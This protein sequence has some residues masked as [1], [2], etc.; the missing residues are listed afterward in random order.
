M[1]V[2]RSN[3]YAI[4]PEPGPSLWL[5][6]MAEDKDVNV[7]QLFDFIERYCADVSA[8]GQQIRRARLFAVFGLD[9]PV[10]NLMVEFVEVSVVVERM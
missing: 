9:I 7:E 1:V 2:V 4:F 8:P 5:R 6:L 10:D 3:D